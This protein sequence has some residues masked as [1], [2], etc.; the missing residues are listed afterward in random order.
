MAMVNTVT[1]IIIHTLTYFCFKLNLN[2]AVTLH[3][4]PNNKLFDLNSKSRLSPVLQRCKEQQDA[5]A[6]AAH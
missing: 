1:H 5:T 3:K 4:P 2:G 6:A